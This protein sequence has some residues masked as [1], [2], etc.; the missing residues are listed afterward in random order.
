VQPL[1]PTAESRQT[2]ADQST[3]ALSI[4]SSSGP[5]LASIVPTTAPSTTSP[6]PIA[7]TTAPAPVLL[8]RTKSK[9]TGFGAFVLSLGAGK[10]SS[11]TGATRDVPIVLDS[12]EE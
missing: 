5:S 12:D 10:A 1:H 6:A 4:P 8:S 7:P 3:V 11:K 2:P 9:A